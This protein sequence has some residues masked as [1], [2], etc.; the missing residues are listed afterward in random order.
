MKK[1]LVFLLEFASDKR[2]KLDI[3]QC[4]V[5]AAIV[6]CVKNQIDH[7][8]SFGGIEG[9]IIAENGVPNKMEFHV[10]DGL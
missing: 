7:F 5:S 9:H 6:E 2:G 10:I 1:K 8:L 3:A 4:H